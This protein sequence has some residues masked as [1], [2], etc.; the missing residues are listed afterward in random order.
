MTDG[1]DTEGKGKVISIHE[2]IRVKDADIADWLIYDNLPR[3]SLIDRFLDRQ[4]TLED[5]S[6]NSFTDAGDFAGRP[7]EFAVNST[8]GSL[9]VL[10]KRQGTVQAGHTRAGL[11]LEKSVSSDTKRGQPAYRLQVYQ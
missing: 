4:V 8:D 6:R 11:A 9:D 5:Y 7:Y 3:S 10:L 2:A 1:K